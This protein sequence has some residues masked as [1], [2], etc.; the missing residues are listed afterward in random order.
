MIPEL[1]NLRDKVLEL[2]NQNKELTAE[3]QTLHQAQIQ[4]GHKNSQ[5]DPHNH[6][7]KFK[8]PEGTSQGPGSNHKAPPQGESALEDIRSMLKMC[9]ANLTDF[10]T[11]FLSEL[12]NEFYKLEYDFDEVKNE[13][14]VQARRMEHD[15]IEKEQEISMLR[16]DVIT[17]R[18]N[19]QLCIIDD[20]R[21]PAVSVDKSPSKATFH[22]AITSIENSIYLG[23]S[24]TPRDGYGFEEDRASQRHEKDMIISSGGAKRIKGKDSTPKF[25]E[26][27]SKRSVEKPRNV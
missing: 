17:L 6:K 22:S 1:L 20:H 3:L 9:L 27:K 16:K 21:P 26:V 18:N 12:M 23:K 15:I 2:K 14:A 24:P 5:M 7:A 4:A 25:S 13:K 19:A 8:H 10:N 11:N